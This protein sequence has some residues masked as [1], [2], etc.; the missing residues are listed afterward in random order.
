M[1][2]IIKTMKLN[3]MPGWLMVKPLLP[4]TKTKTGMELPAESIEQP[5]CGEIIKIGSPILNRNESY[6]LPALKEGM[7]V[8]FQKWGG[9]VMKVEGQ[10]Y[11]FLQYKDL[12]ATEEK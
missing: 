5:P 2:D 10:S 11:M 8:Y 7:K 1:Y 4:E 3:L 12:I 6:S 9:L